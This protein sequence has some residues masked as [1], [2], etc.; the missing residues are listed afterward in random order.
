MGISIETIQRVAVNGSPVESEGVEAAVTRSHWGID[1]DKVNPV[2]KMIRSM[3]E[4]ARRGVEDRAF[5]GSVARQL[6]IH[7]AAQFGA[8]SF[9]KAQ[10]DYGPHVTDSRV[11]KRFGSLVGWALDKSGTD[12]SA[13]ASITIDTVHAQL[14]FRK[15]AA[16]ISK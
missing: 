3:R 7:I 2:D 9:K 14:A 12:V 15:Q 16:G 1:D 8:E 11:I 13:I 5:V 6:G 10:V 4:V